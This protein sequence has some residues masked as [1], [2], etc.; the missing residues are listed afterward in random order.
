MGVITR[1]H[2][3]RGGVHV[4][5]FNPDSL[6][7]A[8]LD[9]VWLGEKRVEIDHAQFSGKDWLVRFDNVRDRDAAEALRNQQISVPRAVFADLKG[10][11]Y[12]HV[13]LIGLSV[14]GENGHRH[15]TVVHVIEYP[16]VD[17][18]VVK[19]ATQEFEIPLTDTFV[20]DVVPEAGHVLVV[21][22]AIKDLLRDVVTK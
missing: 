14:L 22:A 13:D 15:G 18:L 4:T 17:C 16:T 11:E 2:G 1:P 21:N 8:E 19:S 10:D 3:I 7:L 9:A 12:Y 20:T 6:L 5:M